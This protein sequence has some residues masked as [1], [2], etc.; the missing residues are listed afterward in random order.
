METLQKV[1]CS[2][3]HKF[4]FFFFWLVKENH[5]K[6]KVLKTR[7]FLIKYISNI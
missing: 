6:M 2:S 4:F 7:I 1:K 5:K 3:D